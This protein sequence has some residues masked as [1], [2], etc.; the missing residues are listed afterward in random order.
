M[1]NRLVLTTVLLFA[2]FQIADLPP[3]ISRQASPNK[4]LFILAGQ[5]NMARL[6]PGRSFTP[7]VSSAFGGENVIVVKDAKGGQPIMRWYKHW[8]VAGDSNDQKQIG[9][10]YD[11]LMGKIEKAVNGQQLASVTFVWMQGERDAGMKHGDVYATSLNGLIQQLRN[12]LQLEDI[13]VV[14]GRLNDHGLY[15]EGKDE[16]R[17]IRRA[18]VTVANEQP[19]GAWVNT[20]D[21]NNVKRKNRVVHDLHLTDAGYVELG[22]RFADESIQLIINSMQTHPKTTS[23]KELNVKIR[24]N[25]VFLLADDQSTYSVGCYGNRDVVTPNMDQLASDGIVFDR[26]YNT[27]SICMASR[28]NIFTGMYEYKTGC[29]FSHGKMQPSVWAKSYP[30]LLREAGYLTAFAGKFGLE[31]EGKGHCE[32]E[33]DIWGGGPGQTD[34]K[35]AKNLSMKKYAAKYPHSTLSYAAFGKDVIRAA[36]KNKQPFCLSISFKAPHKP[37]IP[38]P[39]FNDV[40]AG[41][42]F[43]KPKNFGRQFG[44]HLS[45]QSK[46]GRQYPRFTEW[47]YD[48]DYNTEMA[49]YHQQVYGIDVALG[50]IRDELEKQGMAENTV[51]IYTS[52]N[53]YICGSHGFGGK[54]LPMEESSRVPLMIFDPRSPL[55]RKQLRCRRLTGNIDFAPT[56]LEI[57]GL[58]IPENMDGKSLLTL[59]QNPNEG[60]HEQLAFINAFGPLSNQ[61]L[62]CLTADHKYTYWWY[63]DEKMNPTEELFDLQN[64]PLELSNVAKEPEAYE[65]LN[66]MRNRYDQELAKWKSNAVKYNNYERY[67]E[68]FDRMIPIADKKVEKAVPQ[69]SRRTR[70]QNRPERKK[71]PNKGKINPSYEPVTLREGKTSFLHSQTTKDTHSHSAL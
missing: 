32:S 18:Q 65:T 47:N 38:D 68:L 41:K 37:A 55:N 7:A 61:C 45:P 69:K 20:D 43:A 66:K 5:S 31:V 48:S 57:A 15:K 30:V 12:D 40:Y 27:T 21:L 29:N 11:R 46:T 58:P 16:W 9:D 53:G 23:K 64:D 3:A 26:H 59:L 2:M 13:N 50:M 24:P 49:K 60:G 35:T 33:F 52:D 67:G 51:V 19:H 62:T 71:K 22:K 70:D 39:R 42:K 1:N 44:K 4:H 36:A 56:F 54:V 17:K 28:A 10:L 6:D 63:G 25:I 8:N 34:Y 14:I